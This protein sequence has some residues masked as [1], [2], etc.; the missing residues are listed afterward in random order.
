[1]YSY[2]QISLYK[3]KLEISLFLHATIQ[4]RMFRS[5]YGKIWKNIA[6][7]NLCFTRLALALV[8]LFQAGEKINIRPHSEKRFQKWQLNQT[9]ELNQKF[10]LQQEDLPGNIS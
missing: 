9:T 8:F 7:F 10:Y 6:I 3:Q 4:T 2:I 5:S 1:M